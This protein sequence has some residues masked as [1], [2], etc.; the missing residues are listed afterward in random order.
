[1]SMAAEREYSPG[2]K[3]VVIYSHLRDVG[4]LTAPQA[5]RLAG[6]SLWRAYCILNQLSL[7]APLYKDGKHWV[8][9]R[10]YEAKRAAW[11][12]RGKRRRFVY[13]G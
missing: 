3:F 9:L 8:Y 13:G 6:C 7:V 5:S 4:I 2:I 12:K 10:W 11:R 1:M